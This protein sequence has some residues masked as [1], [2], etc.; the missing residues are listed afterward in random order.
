[1][2]VYIN[3]NFDGVTIPALPS[4]WS[5]YAGTG[6][7]VTS[8]VKPHSG[9]KSLILTALGQY[10]YAFEAS[11]VDSDF[12]STWAEMWFSP[13]VNPTNFT[14]P[15]IVQ[16]AQSSPSSQTP[17][18]GY[19]LLF[20]IWTGEAARFSWKY[21]GASATLSSFSASNILS[22]FPSTDFYRLIFT[23][24]DIP[25]G[26]SIVLACYCQRAS[27]S[28]WLV[29]SGSA[30]AW[31]AGA[32]A[33]YIVAVHN[34]GAGSA[35]PPGNCLFGC[36]VSSGIPVY[37]DDCLWQSIPAVTIPAEPG[38][39]EVELV[40][41]AISIDSGISSHTL[42]GWTNSTFVND[43]SSTAQRDGYVG[44]DLGSGNTSIL[45]RVIYSPRSD[46]GQDYA[47]PGMWIDGA[48]S[49]SGP[50]TN[51]GRLPTE[52]AF[53]YT[54]NSI[55]VA[56]GSAF[57]CFRIRSP[58]FPAQVSYLRFCGSLAGSTSWQPA[59]PKITPGAGRFGAGQSIGISTLTAGG[60]LLYTT[61]GTTPAGTYS[62]STL[63]PSGTATL[64]AATS[65]TYTL[66][67]ITSG[68]TLALTVVAG[69]QS[70]T[71]Q[72]S[73]PT[74]A[75]FGPAEFVPDTG[76]TGP[77]YPTDNTPQDWYD[78]RGV[79]IEA[80]TGEAEWDATLGKYVL[81]GGMF[82]TASSGGDVRTR[83]FPFYT[84]TDLYNWH[85]EGQLLGPAPGTFQDGSGAYLSSQTR[86][87]RVVN[88][89]PIDPNKKHIIACHADNAGYL[90]GAVGVATAPTALGPWKWSGSWRPGGVVVRD[91]T[92]FLDAGDGHCYWIADSGSHA[93]IAAYRLDVT[94]DWISPDGTSYTL[95]STGSREGVAIF[96]P[97]LD[98]YY[99]LVTSQLTP[100]GSGNSD[101]KYKSAP[102]ATLALAASG[103]NSGTFVSIFASTPASTSTAHNA[104][105]T[106]IFAP[107]DRSGL[108]LMADT[109]DPGETPVALYH[110][111]MSWR[112]IRLQ[113]MVGGVLSILTPATWTL[114]SL[115]ST[116][117]PSP[118]FFYDQSMSSMNS[119]GI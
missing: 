12:G 52:Y 105:S 109:V 104:Q 49:P 39:A 69:H 26:P 73:V 118:Q 10:C 63:T 116:A 59:R 38:T 56:A 94:A 66:P 115:P 82:A 7:V 110:S 91:G 85:Y 42:V 62:G 23:L 67:A 57:R 14:D 47:L 112:F 24:R 3:E 61:D 33:P 70:G 50:W 119:M 25:D 65:G 74:V 22:L 80:H 100:Y 13:S 53:C 90:F 95:D 79:L 16:R 9:S 43:Y 78:D 48:A 17:P 46:F 34:P 2:A 117:V 98:G 101:E 51:L 76:S 103:L 4:G 37:I 113:D 75:I 6:T 107:H 108:I 81:I 30:A 40:G 54:A 11:L 35:L 19:Q 60:Q 97:T 21:G 1:M 93:S 41:T 64:V 96:G 114:A 27:D 99:F 58:E 106:H 32:M 31:Q 89:S 102:A 83:G 5:S 77:Y 92:L 111:R 72:F 15:F 18:D 88:P 68:T 71:N 28:S 36:Y 86:P 20:G 45:S 87:H 29:Q 44:L 84:S 8:S 55:P